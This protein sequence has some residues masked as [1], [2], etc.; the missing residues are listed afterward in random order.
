MI[1]FL[2]VVFLSVLYKQKISWLQLLLAIIAGLIAWSLKHYWLVFFLISIFAGLA[3][4]FL[5]VR[6][7]W[8]KKNAV[9]SWMLIFLGLSVAASFTHPFFNFNNLLQ[10]IVSLY[11]KLIVFSKG[12]NLIHYY[13]LSP[14]WQ[15]IF[16]NSPWA[17]FSG[18][19]RPF[20]GEGHGLFGF[21]ASL[22]NLLLFLLFL[23]AVVSYKKMI[24]PHQLLYLILFGYCVVLC[25]LLSLSTPNL[26]S[27]SRYRIGFLPFL[28][29]IVC[30]KNP[31]LQRITKRWPTMLWCIFD[32]K[33]NSWF[34]EES[35]YNF[36]C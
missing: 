13:Q 34:D 4:E 33:L 5:S 24:P 2:F 36:W 11:D 10:V 22:E 31:I 3:I 15:S 18:F 9:V 27:L 14:H 21:I 1:Y 32:G 30:Y 6:W 16:I 35:C 8:I 20:I 25:I 19:F 23:S 28:V 29:F 17:L 26:G 12:N 7:S